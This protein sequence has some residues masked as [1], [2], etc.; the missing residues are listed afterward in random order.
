MHER[1]L[2][3]PSLGTG[4]VVRSASAERQA[5]LPRLGVSKAAVMARARRSALALM[6]MEIKVL[7]L[8]TERMLRA[9]GRSMPRCLAWLLMRS[10]DVR[11]V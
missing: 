5:T 4:G 1:R 7:S 3:G 2:N 10:Q 8:R 9:L 11:C 6:V